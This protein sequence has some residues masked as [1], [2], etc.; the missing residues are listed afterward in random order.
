MEKEISV[1]DNNNEKKI[2]A[3]FL[4]RDGTVIKNSEKPVKDPA[5]I[6]YE[7]NAAEGLKA[8]QDLGFQLVMVSNQGG[9]NAGVITKMELKRVNDT[10]FSY[11]RQKGVT[12][13]DNY[14]CFHK[15]D[16]GCECRKPG[17]AL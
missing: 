14:N 1:E 15:S 5:Q 3:I 6:E 7:N 11:L 10:M 12:F 9:V 17:T 16:D 8:M 13:L 4:D 2:K